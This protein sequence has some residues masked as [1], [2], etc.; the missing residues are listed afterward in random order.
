M[1][2]FDIIAKEG[3][4]Y[5]KDAMPGGLLNREL[6]YAGLR[7]AG[8]V[9]SMI[10]T[11]LLGDVASGLLAMDDLRNRQYGSAALNSIGLLPFVPGAAGMIKT[12]AGR[13]PETYADTNKLA[14]MLE[15]AGMRKGYNVS[16]SGSSVSPSQ[17]VTFSKLDDAGD[18]IA[19][20]AR[21]IR[22][23]NHYDRN[24]GM[25]P[26]YGKRFDV[27]EEGGVGDTFEHAVQWLGNEGYPTSLSTRYRDI[28]SW[29]KVW[30]ADRAAAAAARPIAK[31]EK[32]GPHP[33]KQTYKGLAI[34]REGN[35]FLIR[36]KD[37]GSAS[38]PVNLVPSSIELKNAGE[39]YKWLSESSGLLK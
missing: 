27:S 29:D 28:P 32:H 8:E 25:A 31:I 6:D 39:L 24:P 38:I 20:S 15:R 14:D 23:S 33:W 12:A 36:S 3:K 2:I 7:K 22:L 19:D 9:A 17:Y 30:E 16:R 34:N 37:G 5:L 1:N 10:P 21:Q 26:S 11:P 13:Y 35:N 4:Q 18:V